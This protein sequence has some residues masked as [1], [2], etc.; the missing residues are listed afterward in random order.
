M[1]LMDGSKRTGNTPRA[2]WLLVD[3]CA[4][5]RSSIGEAGWLPVVGQQFFDAIRRVRW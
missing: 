5:S 2:A 1:E 4:L 3:S